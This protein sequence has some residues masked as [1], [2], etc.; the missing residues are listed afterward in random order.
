MEFYKKL[1]DPIGS[2]AILARLVRIKNDYLG[3]YKLIQGTNI[4]IIEFRIH[5][6]S[7]YRLYAYKNNN[8]LV[9]MLCAGN[10][11]TQQKD[12]KAAQQIAREYIENGY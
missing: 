3:D 8:V 11:D 12:I 1:K 10:K 4:P 5:C 6:R 7:G 9:V 2:K